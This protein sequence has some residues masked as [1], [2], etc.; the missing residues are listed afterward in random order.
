MFL[1]D[2]ESCLSLSFE[3]FQIQQL[4]IVVIIEIM[5]ANQQRHRYD[6]P[7]SPAPSIRATGKYAADVSP[8]FQSNHFAVWGRAAAVDKGLIQDIVKRYPAD[9]MLLMLG[10]N[11]MGWFYSNALGTLS[12]IKI[13][14]TNARVANP[15]LKFAI[16]NVPM[17]T[18]IG[19]ADLPAMT[20]GYNALLADAIP[21]WSTS[22]SPVELVELRE[23]YSCELDGC[24]AGY[25]GLH[26]NAYGE[27]QIAH[28]FS[29]TLVNKFQ[30]GETPVT[31]PYIATIPA[32]PMPVPANFTVETSPGGIVASWEPAFGAYGYDILSRIQNV[33][34]WV[35]GYVASNR[36]DAIWTIDGEIYDIKVRVS[37]GDS[38]KGNW[39][40]VRSAVAHPQT[41]AAPDNVVVTA[42]PSG[43]DL[44]SD[45][46]S[47]DSVSEYEVLY[48][49]KNVQ[50]SS[51]TSA[52][53]AGSSVHID[54][55]VPDHEYMVALQTWNTAGVG[56]PKIVDSVKVGRESSS[57]LS[58]FVDQIETWSGQ[59]VLA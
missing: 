37:C 25:D 1:R 20:D 4:L 57:V 21:Q 3:H 9:L 36:Y 15:N 19:R 8:D 53:F 18:N 43:F 56:F 27:F 23:N 51:L 12:S 50:N 46:R 7:I 24:P 49:D 26:P 28:A 6:S 58:Q 34:D 45:P 55:L 38:Q 22:E 44:N 16:A 5:W 30:M 29:L 10:F 11:D 2:I 47:G 41:T 52:R 17:R 31:V 13:L 14:V 59:H 33:T 32:R 54:G 35:P 39:T 48:F 40:D 42:T